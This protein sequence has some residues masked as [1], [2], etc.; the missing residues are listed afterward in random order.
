MFRV[1]CYLEPLGI[2][3]LGF[4]MFTNVYAEA[5]IILVMIGVNLEL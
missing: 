2:A 5:T 3:R 4:C 1:V